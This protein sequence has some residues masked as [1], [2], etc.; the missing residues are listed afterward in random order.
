MRH[1]LFIFLR[2]RGEKKQR[3]TALG[4]AAAL[5]EAVR[6]CLVHLRGCSGVVALAALEYAQV[7]LLLLP[8]LQE[9]DAGGSEFAAAAGAVMSDEGAGIALVK[10]L[11]EGD[12]CVC[13][14]VCA[15]VRGNGIYRCLCNSLQQTA[16]RCSSLQHTATHCNTLQHTATHCNTLQH[17]ECTA[18]NG[19]MPPNHVIDVAEAMHGF[20]VGVPRELS[21]AWLSAAA[22]LH[23][24]TVTEKALVEFVS[25]FV[26][27]CVC[28]YVCVFVCERERACTGACRCVCVGT[29]M[30]CNVQVCVC[31]YRHVL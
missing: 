25:M 28:V 30:S 29:D 13:V 11:L 3:V 4:S 8:Q 22:K 5:R 31:G 24:P 19:D 2:K 16:T 21:W 7:L 10:A 9:E 1:P 15:F 23:K 17:T 6:S 14:Y 12:V 18:A 26:R 20:L 27:V